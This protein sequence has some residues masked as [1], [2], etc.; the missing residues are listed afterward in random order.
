[1]LSGR[2]EEVRGSE[3]HHRD[4]DMIL[5]PQLLVGFLK[6]CEAKDRPCVGAQV[7]INE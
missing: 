2:L 7:E 5:Y 1:M 4:T 6:C 3:G